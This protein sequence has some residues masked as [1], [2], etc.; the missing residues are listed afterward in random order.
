M[1]AMLSSRPGVVTSATVKTAVGNDVFRL[2]GLVAT[3]SIG[4]PFELT[5]DLAADKADIKADDLLGTAATVSFALPGGG[6][7]HFSGLVTAVAQPVEAGDV[8]VY[9]LELSAWI[10]ASRRFVSSA[11]V[12]RWV[13]S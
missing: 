2:I 13:G 12:R 3:E 5:L 11:A 6:E 7:R 9:R 4:Q 10:A 8:N 1:S